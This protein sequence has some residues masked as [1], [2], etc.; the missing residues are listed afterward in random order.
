MVALYCNGQIWSD[1]QAIVFDKDGTL[2]NSHPYLQQLTLARIEQIETRVTGQGQALQRAFGLK[3]NHLD[4]AGLMAVG[5][6]RENLIAAAAYIAETGCS[7]FEALTM[8]D[9]CFQGADQQVQA[10]RETCPI[11]PS[12][13]ALIEQL[14]PTGV[15]LAIVSAA[16]T[17]SVERF[18]HD[19]GL[20][21][22]F[23]L[24]LGSDQGRSKPDPALYQWACEQMDVEPR[25]TVMIGDA[26]GDI[27][28]AKKAGAQ[29]V[30]AVQWPHLPPVELMGMDAVVQDLLE[31]NPIP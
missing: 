19:H 13:R 21:P 11:F 23:S 28:M 8:A 4:P 6:R 29:A 1:I 5:S 9:T 16:R 17:A 22:H 31:I 12:G 25:Y 10:N 3:A 26:Q 30:I 20:G 27:T 15:K 2:E 18:V 14:I 7:W 24:L